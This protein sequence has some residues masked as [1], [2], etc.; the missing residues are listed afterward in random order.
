MIYDENLLT[1]YSNEF[2]KLYK[3]RKII[4]SFKDFTKLVAENPK[5]FL[6][7][8][9]HYLSDVFHYHGEENIKHLDLL[10]TKKFLLFEKLSE[11]EKNILG[12]EKVQNEI[13]HSLSKFRRK[14]YVD[15]L[16][17]LYGP[18]ASSKSLTVSKIAAAMENYSKQTDGAVYKFNW[19]FPVTLERSKKGNNHSNKIG[20]THESSKK[21]LCTFAFLDEN[22]ILA[23]I[24]SEFKENPLFLIPMPFRENFLRKILASKEG[25]KEEDVNI[26]THLLSSG[27]SKKNQEI[28]AN[29]LQI[30]DGDLTKVFRHIQ[31]ERFFYSSQYRVGISSIDPQMPID[32]YEKQI[33]INGNYHKIPPYLHDINFHESYGELVEANRGLVE[34]SDLLARPLSHI[35]QLLST[36]ER[37]FIK[38]TSSTAM[39][40][41]VYMATTDDKHMEAFHATAEF[42]FF[43]G[44]FEEIIVPYLL[45]PSQEKEIYAKDLSALKK[46]IDV[47]P[48]TLDLLV[49][50]AIM[51]RM[52]SCNLLRFEEDTHALL[53]KLTPEAKIKLYEGESLLDFFTEQ[54][55]KILTR[56]R[57]SIWE[58]GKEGPI[59]EG[60][61]GPS[62]RDLVAILH[63]SAEK[64]KDNTLTAIEIFN[65]ILEFIKEKNIYEFLQFPA[66]GNY[67]NQEYFL[68]VLKENY[69]KNFEEEI[70]SAMS[71]G[72]KREY[73]LYLERYIRHVVAY[74]KN[75]KLHDK[76]T[77]TYEP[78]SQELMTN[79]EEIL[80]IQGPIEEYRS[81][82]LSR[83]AAYRIENPGID[84]K[85]DSLFKTELEKIKKH[86]F[87]EQK[88]IIETN[89]DLILR[90]FQPEKN[91]PLSEAEE[92]IIFLTFENMKN[93]FG[94]NKK[95][96]QKSVNFVLNR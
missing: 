4:L 21:E 28:L 61:F 20:F 8:A 34:Y 84:I 1:H 27:L 78:P 6:R 17:L 92:K 88:K 31:V 38:L 50:W 79:V 25:T 57:K 51:S 91:S 22:Q 96:I 93:E 94:Y 9:S 37:R 66:Q 54:E 33:T 46:E 40:D 29:M 95:A 62:P 26:P 55:E 63:K 85:I 30:Y 2:N 43:K 13:F 58:D 74:L 75:Q 5:P 80:N 70:A 90:Y 10:D 48:H 73:K 83:I 12:C 87:T 89:Y 24:H 23:K 69:K 71:I 11:K 60:R 36:I 7:D 59:Y 47:A 82:L 44:R 86:F 15:K 81:N 49:L 67:H 72:N 19:I 18:S 77:N 52:K 68:N 42:H 16:I 56:L 64:A 76:T 3:K 35:K 14:G 39:L 65:E 53:Q 45:R 41:I 32:A